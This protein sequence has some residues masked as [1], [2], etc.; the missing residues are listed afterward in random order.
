MPVAR[1]PAQPLNRMPCL[2]PVSI[3][4]IGLAQQESDAS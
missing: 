1:T 4:L 2:F 3:K